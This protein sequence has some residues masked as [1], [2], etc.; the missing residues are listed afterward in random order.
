[1]DKP[2]FLKLHADTFAIIGVNLAIFS[3]IIA[4]C[5]SN[6]SRIDLCNQRIDA[7]QQRSD[8]IQLMIY[9]FLKD[10]KK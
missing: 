10:L 9:D 7:C 1:M 3:V 5:V 2:S 4:L 8:A 6:I